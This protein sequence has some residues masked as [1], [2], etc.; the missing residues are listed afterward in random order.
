MFFKGPHRDRNP[1]T[2]F[3]FIYL[4]KPLEERFYFISSD[5]FDYPNLAFTNT[6]DNEEFVVV[7]M[8]GSVFYYNK[9]TKDFSVINTTLINV[10]YAI[11]FKKVK[12]VAGSIYA[13]GTPLCIYKRENNVFIEY[14]EGINLTPNIL[15]GDTKALINSRFN[16]IDGFSASNM[17]AV[18]RIG[19]VYQ[20]KG[21]SWEKKNF[22][23]EVDL[24][25][26]TCGA[27]GEVYITDKNGGLWRGN[28]NNW[29][30]LVEKS[31]TDYLDAVWFNDKLWCSHFGIMQVWQEDQFVPED[32]LN[33]NPLPTQM[34]KACGKISIS[35]DK[36]RMIICSDIA[37]A[38]YSD[39]EWQILIDNAAFE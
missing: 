24:N 34:F 23:S 11:T 35:P 20:F 2:R 37:T 3:L 31:K 9:K 12:E 14:S 30:Q 33:T 36:K 16:D 10:N 19:N 29:T 18:G 38:M 26:V 5:D 39:G 4:N 28:E 7:D 8:M 17:Y 21:S 32:T 15:A 25:T 13:I 6:P 1:E 22:P 27:D